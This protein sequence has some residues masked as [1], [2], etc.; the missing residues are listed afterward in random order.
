MKEDK[1]EKGANEG[2]SQEKG[3]E[4]GVD[5]TISPEE[6]ARLQKEAEQL[7]QVVEKYKQEEDK[8]KEEAAKEDAQ[9]ELERL[10]KLT[11][12]EK[13]R[14][15]EKKLEE[16]LGGLSAVKKDH[17][18]T[19]NFLKAQATDELSS[20]KKDDQALVKTLVGSE[21]P[22]EVFRAVRALKKAGKI[23]SNLAADGITARK[24]EKRKKSN[25]PW[26]DAA[27]GLMD[28]LKRG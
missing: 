19:L 5:N 1:K 8:R 22:R 11:A 2:E 17:E 25:D 24:T 23:G 18:A 4:K 21:D 3:E 27:L 7:R 10:A 20:L 14:E 26:K 13:A 12:E 28:D 16:A 6:V 15:Y 9:R